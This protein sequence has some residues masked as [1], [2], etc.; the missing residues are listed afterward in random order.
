MNPRGPFILLHPND[1]VLVCSAPTEAGQL[2]MVEDQ[3]LTLPT[4]IPVGHKIARKAIAQGEK[5]LKYGANI[6]SA[7]AAISAGSH[8]HIH[9]M[10][11][12]YIDSHTREATGDE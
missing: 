12:D 2:I 8:V 4:A 11:S 9:N 10:K 1:N 5:I 3:T 7:T 6:G